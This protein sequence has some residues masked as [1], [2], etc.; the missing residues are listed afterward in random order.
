[1]STASLPS[2]LV[3]TESGEAR[4]SFDKLKTSGT[5]DVKFSVSLSRDHHP[6][7]VYSLMQDSR[8]NAALLSLSGIYGFGLNPSQ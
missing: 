7:S 5:F 1:M 6:A 8:T 2:T 4:L 3:W